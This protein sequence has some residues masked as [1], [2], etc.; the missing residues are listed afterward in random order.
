MHSERTCAATRRR[1]GL[2]LLS[3]CLRHWLPARDN[4]APGPG[5]KPFSRSKANDA[6]AKTCAG[7][8]TA[9]LHPC[10]ARHTSL[11]ASDSLDKEQHQ[12]RAPKLR[13]P[14]PCTPPTTPPRPLTPLFRGNDHIGFSDLPDSSG[15]VPRSLQVHHQWCTGGQRGV[16]PWD[17]H[18]GP[19]GHFH[20]SCNQ[21]PTIRS[22]HMSESNMRPAPRL[23]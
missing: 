14:I 23:Y 1:A 22:N 20:K 15:W 7:R 17:H 16:H 5:E 11:R 10:C 12:L 13:I 3:Q 9:H 21:Q 6:R 2:N 19:P 4:K 18:D 8:T